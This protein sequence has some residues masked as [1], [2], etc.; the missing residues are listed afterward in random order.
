MEQ[1]ISIV[2]LGVNDLEVARAFY[3]SLG[4]RIA[5]EGEEAASIVAY[6][7]HGMTLCL[8]PWDK[9]AEDAQVPP[10]GEGFRG[11]VLAYNV[12]AKEEVAKVLAAVETAGGRV[13]K[14]AQ[15]AFWGGHSGIFADPEGHL[16]EVAWNP[17][18]PLGPKGEFRWKGH[19][20]GS[21][22]RE[23]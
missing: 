12:R 22:R 4:W 7:L 17:F 11:V 6:D 9:L 5:N 21:K 19:A 18:A 23:A 10:A 16:W 14:P 15:D 8:Y 13:V 1:R 20:A 3:E 2:T